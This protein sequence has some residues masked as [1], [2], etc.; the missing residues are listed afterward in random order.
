D[1]IARTAQELVADIAHEP[2]IEGRARGLLDDDDGD[3]EISV[4]LVAREIGREMRNDLE[5]MIRTISV[6]NDDAEPARQRRGFI[7]PHAVSPLGGASRPRPF[8]LPPP[9]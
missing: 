8:R 5:Q 7:R 6:G 4:E 9:G 3:R 2:A 1:V